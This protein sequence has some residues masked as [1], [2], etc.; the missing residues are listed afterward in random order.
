[1][2]TCVTYVPFFFLDETSVL[3]N[4]KDGFR[5]LIKDNLCIGVRD[6][7]EPTIPNYK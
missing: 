5:R 3:F 2:S 6:N 7:S 1:M 4:E